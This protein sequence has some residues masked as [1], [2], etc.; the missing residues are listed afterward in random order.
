[1]CWGTW[2]EPRGTGVAPG[3]NDDDD[4]EKAADGTVV[5][6]WTHEGGGGGTD[7]DAAWLLL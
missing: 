4:D 6:L 2:G 3:C 7:G 5:V 1:M